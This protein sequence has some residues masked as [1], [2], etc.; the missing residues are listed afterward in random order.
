[1]TLA[2]IRDVIC[3]ELDIAYP[4]EYTSGSLE[5]GELMM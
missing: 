2:I 4:K 5:V 1:M 3:L